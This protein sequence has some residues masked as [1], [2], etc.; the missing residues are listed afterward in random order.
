MRVFDEIKQGKNSQA[1]TLHVLA[2]AA[3]ETELAEIAQ[4]YTQ[5]AIRLQVYEAA[6]DV[7]FDG[8][9]TELVITPRGRKFRRQDPALR[10]AIYLEFQK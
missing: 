5:S 2:D 9:H 7:R 4:G 8:W 1:V 3:S 10:E 6:K